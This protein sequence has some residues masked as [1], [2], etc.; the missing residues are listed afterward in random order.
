M[1][2]KNRKCFDL[3][4]FGDRTFAYS[5]TKVQSPFYPGDLV[6]RT[7]DRE[8]CSVSGRVGMNGKGLG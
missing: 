8:I 4:K 2:L 1:S 6:I 7:G 5:G 3:G